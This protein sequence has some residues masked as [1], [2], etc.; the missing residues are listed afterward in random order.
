[1]TTMSARLERCFPAQLNEW[2]KDERPVTAWF[3]RIVAVFIVVAVAFGY[4]WMI[5]P[6]HRPSWLVPREHPA[7]PAVHAAHQ[8]VVTS[9][10]VRDDQREPRP[11]GAAGA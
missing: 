1:M 11:P 7:R 9:R 2:V 10:E 3:V 8:G 4:L 6:Q 5:A